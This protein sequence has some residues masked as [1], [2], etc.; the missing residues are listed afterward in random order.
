MVRDGGANQPRGCEVAPAK[1]AFFPTRWFPVKRDVATTT[2]LLLLIFAQQ[3]GSTNK[4]KTKTESEVWMPAIVQ[5]KQGYCSA[6]Q[7]LLP[8]FPFS[9]KGNCCCGQNCGYLVGGYLVGGY[10][11]GG[12]LVGGYLMGRE[13][14]AVANVQ[15]YPQPHNP[16]DGSET[17]TTVV[18]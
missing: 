11:V 18:L 9:L 1:K 3:F 8:L 17:T 2:R 5:P 7:R 16:P 10:L 4:K 6:I 13:W 12:Y 15:D 14:L